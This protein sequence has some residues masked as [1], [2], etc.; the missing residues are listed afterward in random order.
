MQIVNEFDVPAAADAV[1]AFLLDPTRIASCVPGAQLG[2]VSSPDTFN[3][4]AKIK[5]GAI[6]ITYRGTASITDR[7]EAARTATLEAKGREAGGPGTA[8]ATIQMSVTGGP[9]G[10]HVRLE[11]DYRV[12]G[13]VANF[14]RG[15][16][17]DVARK[18]VGQTAGGIKEQL[19]PAG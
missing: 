7:D 17:E 10:A 11:T 6:S 8:T 3:G 13:R 14:G 18:L 12:T 5:V 4:S 16:M 1:F 9:E 19:A 15:V 2:E